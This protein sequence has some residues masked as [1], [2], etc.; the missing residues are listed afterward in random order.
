MKTAKDL[1]IPFT[2]EERR[3]IMLERFF[4]VPS[5]CNYVQEEIPLFEKK[6]PLIIEYC[7]GNGEWIGA[8]AKQFPEFNWLAV[9]KKFVRARMI[10][11]KSF[12]EN[13]PNLVTVCSEASVFTQYF[14]PKA[15]E[16]FINFPDPWP[17]RCHAKHRL[18]RAEF[19][20]L[21]KKIVGAGGK[22]TCVTDDSNYADQIL[23][24]FNKCKGWKLL[25]NGNQWPE[26]GRSFF[27]DL[28]IQRG[29]T[30]HYISQEVL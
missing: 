19:L 29:R 24:E 2:W 21:L 15:S 3:P 6:Q 7:S 14:A 11:L 27:K 4:Y 10:W 25:F 16:V 23:Q 20:Q 9:E 13:L 17:K 28:W 12:R 8:R 22:A 18:I 1:I 26:Y 30:I 5:C